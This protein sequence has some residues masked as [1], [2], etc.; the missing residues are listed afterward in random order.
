[1]LL[2]KSFPDSGLSFL[3]QLQSLDDIAWLSSRFGLSFP[4]GARDAAFGGMDSLISGGAGRGTEAIVRGIEVSVGGRGGPANNPI[5]GL[6][7][8]HGFCL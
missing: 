4:W 6:V 3:L 7:T 1:V 2:L 5:E 8:N